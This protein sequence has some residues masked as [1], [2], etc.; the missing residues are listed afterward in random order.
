MSGDQISLFMDKVAGMWAWRA[1]QQVLRF[2]PVP[3]Q[4]AVAPAAATP[5]PSMMTGL[6]ESP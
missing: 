5:I 4:Q 2:S 1:A 6:S 3:W